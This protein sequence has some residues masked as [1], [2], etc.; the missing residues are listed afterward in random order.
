MSKNSNKTVNGNRSRS[1]HGATDGGKFSLPALATITYMRTHRP[2]M[3]KLPEPGEFWEAERVGITQ[4]D[5]WKMVEHGIIRKAIDGEDTGHE[6]HKWMTNP[7]TYHYAEHMGYLEESPPEPG[8]V[9]CPSCWY[10]SFTNERG[11]DGLRCKSCGE[12]SP[13]KLWVRPEEGTET[14]TGDDNGDEN[15]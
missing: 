15:E 7:D 9:V 6:A 2:A 10:G 1:Y 4:G 3:Q 14:E 11:V 8:E 12:V 5:R 13:K